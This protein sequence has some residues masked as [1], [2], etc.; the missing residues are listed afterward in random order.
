VSE[1]PYGAWDADNHYYEAIDAFTRHMPK[2]LADR[3]VQI[4]ERNGRKYVVAGGVVNRFIPN[5]TFDPVVVP[6]SLDLF[7]RGQVPDDMDPAT[8]MAVEPI[9]PEYRERDRRLAVMDD[10]GLEAACLFPTLGCGIEEALKDDIPATVATL[11]AFNQWLDEDWGFSYQGRIHAVPMIAVADPEAAAAEVDWAVERGARMVHVRPAPVPAGPGRG[12][13]P[14]DKRYDPF[15]QRV[16]E[17][18]VA[19]AF[20]LGDSG[21]N[22]YTGDWG[23]RA[24]FEAFKGTDPFSQVI[25]GDRAI[26]DT[27]AALI[28]HGVFT[29]FPNVR[30][31]SIEN[32][33]DWAVTLLKKL[34][35]TYNQ[36]PFA[37]AE[38]PLE[39]VRRHVWTTPYLE[40]DLRALADLIGVEHVLMGSDW[41]HGEGVAEPLQFVKE[42]TDFSD[43]EVRLIAR[44]NTKELLTL[45]PAS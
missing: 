26:F 11:H 24:K 40:E 44:E 15:W 34:G 8:L 38:D 14:G 3:G 36:T 6:G 27:M 5:P 23:G 2:K 1:L 29:R 28:M 9:H 17:T 25:V 16:S 10:Q 45:R 12:R 21:Y 19:V 18:G 7:F 4:Y 30:V 39:T 22:R 35:K 32:G 41:P 37:F 31:A 20:H 42:L 43:D 13:S 33:S